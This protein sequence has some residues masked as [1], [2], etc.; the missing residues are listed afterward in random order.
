MTHG[1]DVEAVGA[2]RVAVL[3]YV[4]ASG[5][6]NACAVTP[7][8]VKG[9]LT[10]TS[11]LALVAKAAALRRDPRVALT[12]G[13]R[14]V[15]GSAAVSVDLTSAWFDAHL[16][17]PELA[18]YPPA[19]SIMAVPGH[20]RLFGWYVGRV[21]VDV[22]VESTWPAAGDDRTTLTVLDADGRL[23]CTPVP[24]PPDLAATSIRVAGAIP[25]GRATL[26]VREEDEELTDLRQLRLSGEV[27]HGLFEVRERRGTLTPSTTGL[28]GQLRTSHQMARRAK[29]NRRQLETWPRAQL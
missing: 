8:V 14:S 25:D 9:R 29:Q 18:K 3:S 6:P 5:Q 19:R 7:Y 17:V 28:V 24:R 23:V 22:R 21:I 16:R 12:A 15:R 10:V 1:S 11:T 27:R 20:R 26:L 13:G 2:A 4:M